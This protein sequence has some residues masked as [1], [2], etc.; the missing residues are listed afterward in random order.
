MWF[1]AGS[2]PSAKAKAA[3]DKGP[4]VIKDKA[5]KAKK[6]KIIHQTNNNSS[7]AV[8]ESILDLII[9]F[10]YSFDDCIVKIIS[11]KII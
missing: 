7:E 11:P 9:D 8:I 2:L 10:V 4:K 1:S 5:I 3:K 6:D